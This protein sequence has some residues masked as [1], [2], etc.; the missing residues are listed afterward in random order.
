[1]IDFIMVEN[2]AI[3]RLGLINDFVLIDVF[4]TQ[5][6]ECVLCAHFEVSVVVHL[7]RLAFDFP[8]CRYF[9]TAADRRN[10]STRATKC[11][12]ECAANT[13]FGEII[14]E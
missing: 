12:V 14:S 7:P 5:P 13:A 6:T 9:K 1:M 8:H 3:L 11:L 10:V 4:C 2:S